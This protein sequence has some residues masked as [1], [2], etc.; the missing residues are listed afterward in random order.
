MKKI[1]VISIDRIGLVGE[2]SKI[3]NRVNGNIIAHTADVSSDGTTAM[4]HFIADVELDKEL[5][6]DNLSRRLRKIKNVRQV[7]ITDI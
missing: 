7:R 4:S 3:L 6:I 1:E 2:I 5:D